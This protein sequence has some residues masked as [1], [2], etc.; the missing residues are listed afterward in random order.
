[1]APT[2]SENYSAKNTG[3]TPTRPTFIAPNKCDFFLAFILLRNLFW[4]LQTTHPLD[5][6]PTH[7]KSSRLLPET[8]LKVGVT[9]PCSCWTSC[10][11]ALPLLFPQFFA[12]VYFLNRISVVRMQGSRRQRCQK[13]DSIRFKSF[14]PSEIVNLLNRLTFGKTLI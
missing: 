5:R 13:I 1:M 6:P 12:I 7:C 10:S 8:Y 9:A 3:E 11:R 4:T 14:F 2:C